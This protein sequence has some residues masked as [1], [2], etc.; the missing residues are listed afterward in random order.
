MFTG[1]IEE[2][3]KI[4]RITKGSRSYQYSIE[5]K[6][7]LDDLKIGNSVSTDGACLTVVEKNASGFI[8]DIMEETVKRTNFSQL[9]IGDSINLER[10]LKL[11]DRLGGHL[12]SGHIDGIGKITK[13]QKVDIANLIHIEAPQ[14]ILNQLIQKGSVAIDGISLTVIEV[15]DRDFQIGIIPHTAKETTLLNKEIGDLV[16]VETD[17]M[18]KYIQRFLRQEST[19]KTTQA[20]KSSGLTMDFLTANGYI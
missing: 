11:S 10:A 9:K 2:I 1:L 20:K 4:K 16:N 17:L 19:E 15:S 6:L 13:I 5:A 3:G 7:I 14:E 8:V 12:V 18:G